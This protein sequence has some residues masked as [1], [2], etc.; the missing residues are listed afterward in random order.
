MM[1]RIVA[2]IL[3]VALLGA[4]QPPPPNVP[5]VK[6]QSNTQLVV[7]IVTVKDKN[8]KPIEDLTAKDFTLTENGVPQT[9]SFC[10]FQKLAEP[11]PEPAP[12]VAAA[13]AAAAPTPAVQRVTQ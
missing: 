11:V 9:I 1:G 13:P 3:C 7:E 10:E 5:T 4:Q 6:F 12:A 2:C 8:G